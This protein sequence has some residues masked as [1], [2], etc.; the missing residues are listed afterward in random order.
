MVVGSS[1]YIYTSRINCL[2]LL[3]PIKQ[4]FQR[5]YLIRYDFYS[6]LLVYVRDVHITILKKKKK[7]RGFSIII[8]V[9]QNFIL[10]FLLGYSGI[11]DKTHVDFGY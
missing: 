8:V 3:W 11:R 1:S 4:R 10:L 9:L 5:H 7:E 2:F 6:S